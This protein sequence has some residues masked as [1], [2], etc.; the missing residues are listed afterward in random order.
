[1]SVDPPGIVGVSSDVPAMPTGDR[2]TGTQLF[3]GLQNIVADMTKLFFGVKLG[4]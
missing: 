3:L 2:L 1:M 4:L